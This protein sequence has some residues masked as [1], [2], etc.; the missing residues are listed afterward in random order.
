MTGP[1]VFSPAAPT[2]LAGGTFV[3]YSATG[4]VVCRGTWKA[5]GFTGLTDF[6]ASAQGQEGGVLS[7][8]VTHYRTTMGMVMTGIPM[9]ITSTVNAP[10]GYGEGITVGDFTQP[11]GGTVTIR[12]LHH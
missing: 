6:G 1:G 4:A 3:H 8:V 2:V 7:L 12:P 10:A 9:T 5:T 11:A